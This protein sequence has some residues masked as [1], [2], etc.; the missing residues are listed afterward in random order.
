MPHRYS[1]IGGLSGSWTVLIGYAL[2]VNQLTLEETNI[3]LD[4]TVVT[5]LRRHLDQIATRKIPT[6]TTTLEGNNERHRR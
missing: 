5:E 6:P 3:V 4:A 2:F 1:E